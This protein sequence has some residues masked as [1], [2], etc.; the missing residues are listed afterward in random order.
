M[1][2]KLIFIVNTLYN[3]VLFLSNIFKFNKFAYRRPPIRLFYLNSFSTF[4]SII[5][6]SVGGSLTDFFV[7]NISPIFFCKLLDSMSLIKEKMTGV[8]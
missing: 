7:I 5:F 2:H 6:Q 1:F 8:R 4:L 3:I